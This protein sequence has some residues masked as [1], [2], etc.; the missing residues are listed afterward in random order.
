MAKYTKQ[1]AHETLAYLGFHTHAVTSSW[2]PNTDVYETADRLV[3]RLE[4][5]GVEK[6]DLEVE[7]ED[8]LLVVRGYRRDPCRQKPCSFRQMEIDYGRFHNGFLHIEVP[9][10]E[11][12]EP[13]ALTVVVEDFV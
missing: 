6:D 12:A 7:L 8:R 11:A 5:A 4:L 2:A 10:T 9:K 3:V 1:S 13:M